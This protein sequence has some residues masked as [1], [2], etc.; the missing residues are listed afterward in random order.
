MNPVNELPERKNTC[1]TCYGDGTV[2]N[3]ECEPEACDTCGGVGEVYEEDG[4]D[5]AMEHYWE[6]IREDR[7]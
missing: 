7:A 5:D 1:P 4:A 6:A 3:L 2:E